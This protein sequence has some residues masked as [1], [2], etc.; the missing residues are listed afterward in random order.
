MPDNHGGI[1]GGGGDLVYGCITVWP[2][3]DSGNSMCYFD[4]LPFHQPQMSYGVR[5]A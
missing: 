2:C 5:G 4:K 1:A 3:S